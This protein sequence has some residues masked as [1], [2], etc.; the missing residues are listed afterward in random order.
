MCMFI[1]WRN[2][3]KLDRFVFTQVDSKVG[4]KC[5]GSFGSSEKWRYYC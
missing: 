3:R 4:K 2:L 5:M 1:E